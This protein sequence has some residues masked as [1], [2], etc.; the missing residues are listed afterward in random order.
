MHCVTARYQSS[1]PRGRASPSTYLNDGQ[2]RARTLARWQSAED[3]RQLHRAVRTTQLRARLRAA[4]GA[5]H[6]AAPDRRHY[7]RPRGCGRCS[8]SSAADASGCRREARAWPT[9]AAETA[10]RVAAARPLVRAVLASAGSWLFEHRVTR[11]VFGALMLGLALSA[12]LEPPFSGLDML[13][14]LGVVVIGPAFSGATL[15]ALLGAMAWPRSL[16]SGPRRRNGQALAL[17]PD[18]TPRPASMQGCPGR[19]PAPGANGSP[20]CRTRCA[21]ATRQCAG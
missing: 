10:D 2:R 11:S 14:S 19:P 4:H 7:A 8:S 18:V 17:A 5:A 15:G 21:D 20:A 1:T 16:R 6:T 3:P 9:F 13:P 12:L